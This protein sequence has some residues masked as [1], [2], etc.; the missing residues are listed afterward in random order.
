MHW[1][2]WQTTT[3]WASVALAWLIAQPDITAPLASVTNLDQLEDMLRAAT[4]ELNR[5]SLEFLNKASAWRKNSESSA[6][7]A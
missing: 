7:A 4:L 6:H 1:T 2:G 5:A 3:G